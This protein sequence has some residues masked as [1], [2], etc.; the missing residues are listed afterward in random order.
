MGLPTWNFK[1]SPECE[2]DWNRLDAA[3]QARILNFIHKRVIVA[4]KTPAFLQSLLRQT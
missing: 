2:K 1:F 3:I 4:D